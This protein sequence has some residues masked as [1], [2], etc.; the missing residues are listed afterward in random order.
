MQISK[1]CDGTSTELSPLVSSLFQA[2]INSLVILCKFYFTSLF[3]FRY[4]AYN[5]YG[6]ATKW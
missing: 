6:Y 5:V 3:T 2:F 1:K 4:A